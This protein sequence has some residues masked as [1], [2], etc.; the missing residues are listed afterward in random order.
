MRG[1][2][3]ASAVV[4]GAC[5]GQS[6][7]VEDPV[8]GI[9]SAQQETVMRR[10]IDKEWPLTVGKGT[11]ACRSG[12]VLFRANGVTYALND[13]AKAQG[14]A[15]IDSI[16][17]NQPSPPPSNPLKGRTQNERMQ[18]FAEY[19]KCGGVTDCPLL[20]GARFRLTPAELRLIFDEGTERSWP[21]LERKRADLQPLIDRGLKLCGA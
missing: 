17:G 11:L 4:C 18:I 8:E 19:A 21:P 7:N 16:R 13:A 20:V 2:L 6:N 12:A 15:S 9:A 5:A 14:F 10:T 3:I 1:W